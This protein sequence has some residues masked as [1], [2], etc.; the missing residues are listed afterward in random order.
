MMRRLVTILC[1]KRRT[2][3]QTGTEVSVTAKNPSTVAFSTRNPAYDVP[4]LNQYVYDCID[5]ADYDEPNIYEPLA[6]DPD[7]SSKV[8][9]PGYD[10]LA[11]DYLLIVG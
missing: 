9:S 11:P 2:N 1:R 5:D 6:D 7:G 8:A 3:L 4:E 10:V